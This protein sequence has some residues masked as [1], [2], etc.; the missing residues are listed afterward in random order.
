MHFIPTDSERTILQHT[1]IKLLVLKADALHDK[2]YSIH[3]HAES[4]DATITEADKLLKQIDALLSV[5]TQ[6]YD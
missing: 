3:I 6:F 4:F 1:A 2:H 5:K